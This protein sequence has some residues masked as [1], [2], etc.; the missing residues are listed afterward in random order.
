MPRLFPPSLD[1]Q[2]ACVDRE[3]VM[4]RRVYPRLVAGGRMKQEAADDEITTML[5]VH[6]TLRWLKDQGAK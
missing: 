6:S 2:I 1:D 4:R 5:E 3:I